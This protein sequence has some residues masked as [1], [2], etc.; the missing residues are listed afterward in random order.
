MGSAL[1]AH[2][3]AVRGGAGI[4]LFCLPHSH[5]P[6]VCLVGLKTKKIISKQIQI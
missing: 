5:S 2:L 1:V 3:G 6:L 4:V